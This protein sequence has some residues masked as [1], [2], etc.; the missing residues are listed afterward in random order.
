MIAALSFLYFLQARLDPQG[1]AGGG[2]IV[3]PISSIPNQSGTMVVSTRR[4]VCDDVVHDSAVYVYLH[5]PRESHDSKSLILRYADDFRS[6]SPTI[7]WLDDSHLS[8]AT[9]DVTLITKMI[10]ELSNI[11]IVYAVG[12]ESIPR[13]AWQAQVRDMEL[14]AVGLIIFM[15]TA[16]SLIAILI[17]SFY[18]DNRS[19]SAG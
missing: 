18:R 1:N 4:T 10:S 6:G 8:I 13:S 17:R 16:L 3:E 2:C 12:R 15:T 14:I 9:G 19:A 7:I 5:K 11:N